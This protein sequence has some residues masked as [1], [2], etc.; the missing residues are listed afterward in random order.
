MQRHDMYKFPGQRHVQCAESDS[1]EVFCVQI[2]FA[3]RC[4]VCRVLVLKKCCV[5]RLWIQICTNSILKQIFDA[6]RVLWCKMY[7]K[8]CF[9]M[10][11]LNIRS[12]TWLKYEK[13][14]KQKYSKFNILIQKR[15][16]HDLT[17]RDILVH[18]LQLEEVSYF[19]GSLELFLED[20]LEPL[21]HF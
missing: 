14:L 10:C 12:A 16:L 15:T 1:K 6:R 17:K 3:K 13:L 20:K 18:S 11:S 8:K 7:H 9:G 2:L 21:R 4:S 19:F 5:S